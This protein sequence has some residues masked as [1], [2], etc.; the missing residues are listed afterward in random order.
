MPLDS[1]ERTGL[2]ILPSLPPIVLN[3]RTSG[4]TGPRTKQSRNQLKLACA[5][6]VDAVVRPRCLI[7]FRAFSLGP[8]AVITTTEPGVGHS[9][10]ARCQGSQVRLP[11]DRICR[12]SDRYRTG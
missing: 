10:M 8:Y 2:S 12:R 4:V 1:Q 5:A 9:S 11:T 6:P 3:R 7:V